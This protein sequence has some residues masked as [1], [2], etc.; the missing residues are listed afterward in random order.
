MKKSVVRV[1]ATML[2]LSL[3]GVAC[4]G[5]DDSSAD[6]CEGNSKIAFF[7]AL[8]G[9]AGN[10]GINIKKGLDLA[11]AQHNEANPDAQIDV[12]AYDS[13]G[14]PDQAP[15]LADKAI[16]DVCVKGIV[17]PAFSGESAAVN[18]KFEEA[19]LPLI[20]PSATN[21][22]LSTNGWDVF[23][24]ALAGDDKQGPGAASRIIADGKTKVGVIDDNSEYG[25]GL[26]DIVQTSLGDKA[27]ELNSLDPE[28]SDYSA[29]ITAAK[30]AGVDAVFFGGYYAAAGKLAKQM[31]DAGVTAQFYSGDGSKD[32]GFIEAAGP[33]AEGAILTCTCAPKEVNPEFLK[34]FQDA[35]KGEDPATYAAEAYDAASVFLAAIKDGK[36]SRAD[37]LSFINSYDAAGVTKQLNW[38]ESGEVT[39]S[40]VYAYQV[41]NGVIEGL[42]LIK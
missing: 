12:E 5:S 21:P 10:L 36:T 42:G 35:N 40:A 1:G 19:G 4:G 16:A 28:A 34:A 9:D 26:A 3:V 39:G 29:V 13:Q 11:V 33:A 17:G 32:D 7:G 41:K 14:D 24:R 30:D 37:I 18:A 23:H 8:T 6:A 27:V 22:A 20:T 31:A 38:D 15:A 2:V 25:K